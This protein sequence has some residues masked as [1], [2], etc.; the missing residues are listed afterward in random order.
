VVPL[1]EDELPPLPHV[2]PLSNKDRDFFIAMLDNPP[3]P[4]EALKKLMR[5]ETPKI[6]E[7]G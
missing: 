6:A 3:P 1:S 4:N 7:G 5:G 2:Q